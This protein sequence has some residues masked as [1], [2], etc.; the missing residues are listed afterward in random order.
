MVKL[1]LLVM[2]VYSLLGQKRIGIQKQ[3]GF[4]QLM[5]NLENKKKMNEN[6]KIITK[7]SVEFTCLPQCGMSAKF[8][9]LFTKKY[10][11]QSFAYELNK[12]SNNMI[13]FIQRE[14]EKK[15]KNKTLKQMKNIVME[16]LNSKSFHCRRGLN[17]RFIRFS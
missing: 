10:I 3:T 11:E 2:F 5:E 8:H 4:L 9:N 7:E 1:L 17:S 15:N 13:K 16:N 12:A 6:Q 14:K